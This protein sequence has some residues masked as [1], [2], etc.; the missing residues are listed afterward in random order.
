M[1]GNVSSSNI[2]G[3]KENLQN[4]T[5][6]KKN[7]TKEQAERERRSLAQLRFKTKTVI[8]DD[9]SYTV[10]KQKKPL[11]VGAAH[12]GGVDIRAEALQAELER[13]QENLREKPKVASEQKDEEQLLGDRGNTVSFPF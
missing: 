4:Y 5:L 9:E 8:E 11:K 10:W 3:D 12:L 1:K 13:G 2:F 6:H 7:L